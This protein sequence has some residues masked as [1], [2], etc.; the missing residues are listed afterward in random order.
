RRP[1][2]ASRVVYLLLPPSEGKTTGGRGRPLRSRRSEPGPLSRARSKTLA[3]L[4]DLVSGDR[5]T[6]RDALLLP[7]GIAQDALAANAEVLDSAT[8]SALRRYSGSCTRGSG[9]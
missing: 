8:T 7:D 5:A 1:A 4:L 2:V 9:F 3:A 6:A